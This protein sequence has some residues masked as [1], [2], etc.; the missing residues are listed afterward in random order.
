[1]ITQPMTEFG[2][3]DGGPPGQPRSARWRTGMAALLV[4]PVAILLANC[5]S[6]HP[7]SSASPVVACS[8]L[9]TSDVATLTGARSMASNSSAATLQSG[10]YYAGRPGEP[11]L[12]T[13]VSWSTQQ[14][15]DFRKLHDLVNGSTPATSSPAAP[16]TSGLGVRVEVDGTAAFWVS[17]LAAA[18]PNPIPNMNQL[19]ATKKNYVVVLN[20]TGLDVTQATRVLGTMLSHL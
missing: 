13:T 1:M 15:A 6:A 17:P 8:L 5:G 3:P 11:V 16:T 12:L 20:S 2:E 18:G 14:L 7:D 9:S 4:G 19:T 10:C